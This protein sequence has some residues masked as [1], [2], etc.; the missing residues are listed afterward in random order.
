MTGLTIPE[1]G[2]AYESWLISD[3]GATALSTG[4]MDVDD[5]GNVNHTF[6]SPSGENLVRSY[7][8]VWISVEPVPDT[9]TA[10]SG[11]YAFQTQIEST[12]LSS[13]RAL[14]SDWPADSG[15]GA[16]TRLVDQLEAAHAEA[17][18]V[19]SR[20]T[21]ATVSEIND[22]I[23]RVVN[24]I[25]GPNGS[26]YADHDA[27]G[28]I[29]SV[30]DGVGAIPHANEVITAASTAQSAHGA[31]AQENAQSSIDLMNL[32]VSK[33]AADVIGGTE[34]EAR[35]NLGRVA[36][37]VDN[38]LNGLDTN[39]DGTISGSGEAGARQ[40]YR[41]AQLIGTYILVGGAVVTTTPDPVVTP[42]LPSTGDSTIPLLAQAGLAI[43]LILMLSGGLLVTT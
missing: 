14:V 3:D 18:S 9:D 5:E 30:G 17:S 40:A 2:T 33:A 28:T 13:A 37:L 19:A 38:A 34:S 43:A 22:S 20:S 8:Q 24:A 7:S 26:N 29:E 41:E 6:T 15:I 27:D 16:A 23:E 32:A 10:P 35:L 42:A 25:E 31:T 4:G 21:T 39:L 11:T 36:G 12:D 1:E